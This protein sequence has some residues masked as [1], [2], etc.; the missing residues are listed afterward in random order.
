M[1]H[2][3]QAVFTYIVCKDNGLN[4]IG[5]EREYSPHLKGSYRSAVPTTHCMEESSLASP[6]S[7]QQ[8]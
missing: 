2:L 6:T 7:T 5:V 4:V 8:R 3:V 1:W